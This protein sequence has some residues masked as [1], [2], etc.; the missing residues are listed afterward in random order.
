MN[1]QVVN[2]RA[3]IEL[4]Q[5][6]TPLTGDLCSGVHHW[7]GRDFVRFV[8]LSATSSYIIWLLP[9]FLLQVLFPDKPFAHLTVSASASQRT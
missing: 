6:R 3:Y 7:A 1:K 5:H 2:T 9:L 8:S 4:V